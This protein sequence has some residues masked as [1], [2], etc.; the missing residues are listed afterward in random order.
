MYYD[1]ATIKVASP[2][3]EEFRFFVFSILR[4]DKGLIN[5]KKLYESRKELDERPKEERG[6]VI[7]GMAGLTALPGMYETL[8]K[9]GLSTH[10]PEDKEDLEK[11]VFN[12]EDIRKNIEKC[13]DVIRYEYHL[14]V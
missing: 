10:N 3:I 2:F 13:A 6:Y 1:L 9:I 11:I 12:L 14:S 4:K 5:E 8:R 7:K